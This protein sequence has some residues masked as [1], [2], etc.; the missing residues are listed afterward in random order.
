MVKVGAGLSRPI[1]V[2]HGIRQGCPI[3]CQLYSL[4]IKPSLCRLRDQLSGFS[5]T[6]TFKS[7]R[8]FPT[9]SAYAD[10][11]NIF[12]SNQGDVLGLKDTLSL[13][14]KESSAWVNWAKSRD[15]PI[16]FFQGR[17]QYRLL[18]VKE[19][20]NGYLE[21]IFI[22]SKRENI[23]VNILNNTNSKT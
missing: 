23:G 1:P 19:A 2:K 21:P 18:A 22:C 9:L 14:E 10:D 7:E 15:R 8:G 5:L 12:V 11:V 3:S 17:C 20:D 13:Y 6:G 4:A 16:C